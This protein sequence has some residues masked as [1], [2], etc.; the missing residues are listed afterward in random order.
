MRILLIW[1][2]LPGGR[3]KQPARLIREQ[4]RRLGLPEEYGAAALLS[5]KLCAAQSQERSAD[6][7]ETNASHRRRRLLD[8]VAEICEF[9]LS[10]WYIPIL[11]SGSARRT[12]FYQ[13]MLI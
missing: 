6:R 3:D 10:C 12:S 11:L 7:R 9:R 2:I 1:V 13:L 5:A 8:I 4:H